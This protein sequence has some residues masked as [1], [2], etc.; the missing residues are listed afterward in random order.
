MAPAAGVST[1]LQL[2]EAEGL[3]RPGVAV[4]VDR[5]V[6]PRAQWDATPLRYGME[7]TVIQAVCGG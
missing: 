3:A 5:N 2:L 7:I 6:V 1:L 4:A